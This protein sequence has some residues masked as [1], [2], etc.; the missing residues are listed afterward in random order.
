MLKIERGGN[1]PIYQQIY[2]QIKADILSGNLPKGFRITSTRTLAKELYV[3]RNSVENAYEQLAL[4]G[5][6]TSI[7]GSGY[8]VNEIAP[9]LY[10]EPARETHQVG[11]SPEHLKACGEI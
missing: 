10:C 9:D 5:Y 11:L 7:P 2:E 3:G 4:E 8:T 1:L 6:I